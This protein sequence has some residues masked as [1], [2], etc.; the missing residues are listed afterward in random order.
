MS[1]DRRFSDFSVISAVMGV[2]VAQEKTAHTGE[3]NVNLAPFGD[4]LPLR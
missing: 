2:W 1:M 3:G 4:T